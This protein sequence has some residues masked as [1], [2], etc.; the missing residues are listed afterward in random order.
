MLAS[1]CRLSTVKLSREFPLIGPLPECSAEVQRTMPTATHTN[2]ENGAVAMGIRKSAASSR[3]SDRNGLDTLVAGVKSG[4]RN[5][6]PMTSNESWL[7]ALR[8]HTRTLLDGTAWPGAQRDA[9]IGLFDQLC[10]QIELDD[11]APAT[12]DV[13][14]SLLPAGKAISPQDAARCVRDVARTSKFL[15]GVV[16]AITEAR[17]RFGERT[18]RVLYAGTGPFAPLV[19]PIAHKWRPDEVRYTLVDVHARS[20][21]AVRHLASRMAV[22]DRIDDFVCADACT[23]R[24]DTD[25]PPHVLICETMQAALAK[26]PQVSITR[27]LASQLAQGGVIVPERIA[28]HLTLLKPSKEMTLA[29]ESMARER[30]E[31]GRVLTVD[32]R[33]DRSASAV[34]PAVVPEGMETFLR[35][36]IQV[37][38]DICLGDYESGLTMPMSFAIE[39]TPAPGQTIEFEYLVQPPGP[40]LS[41][42]LIP[43]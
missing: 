4:C 40:R 12:V 31:L 37:F 30:I 13:V 28:L 24:C 38:A 18:V 19:L 23:Y 14:E 35:T 33:G 25:E 43:V 26:E 6:G 27:N 39:P 16:A 8:A 3:N 1:G 17:R 29:G 20:V 34:W 15:R 22:L 5:D 36:H 2:A 21:D 11:D 9:A 32:H 42:R 41:Y 7:A 10:E